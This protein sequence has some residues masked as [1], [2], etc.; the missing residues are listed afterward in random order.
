MLAAC[1]LELA[2]LDDR[3]C[4]HAECILAG[5][6]HLDGIC[7]CLRRT[8][9]AVRKVNQGLLS[10]LD[11]LGWSAF[12]CHKELPRIHC[13]CSHVALVLVKFN[14]SVS[15]HLGSVAELVNVVHRSKEH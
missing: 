12:D 8:S 4:C 1:D 2:V 9:E 13:S 14:G 3:I 11:N 15:I 10:H 6:V 5:L 7:H